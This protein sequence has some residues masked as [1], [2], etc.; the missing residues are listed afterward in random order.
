MSRTLGITATIGGIAILVAVFAPGRSP[1]SPVSAQPQ[2]VP[3]AK[4]ATPEEGIRAITAEY[5][6][7]FNAADAKSAA[8]L[9]TANGE[10]IGADGARVVGRDAIE[11]DL[12]A[13]FKANPKVQATVNIES[14]RLIGRG[15]AM[16]EGLVT[17]RRPAEPTPSESRYSALHVNEEG[18]W[19][20]ASVREWELDHATDIDL[21][22]LEWM[23]GEWKAKGDAEVH[24][25]YAWDESKTFINGKY[26]VEKDG[27][28]IST[29]KQVFARNPQGGLRSWMFDSSGTTGEAIWTRD[30]TRWV[31]DGTATLTDG[32]EVNSTSVIIPIGKDSFTWQATERSIDGVTLPS[33][34]PLK[35]TR[36]VK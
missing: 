35:V 23:V 27:K 5:V 29:G 36:V 33:L 24:L 32:L 4:A 14:I 10:Y 28:V 17:V 9:W 22:H 6:K 20:A 15:T 13:F 21:K 26:T 7:A 2:P 16:V 12:A 19:H 25:S 31:S 30:G 18:V 1:I 34:P 3:P 8:L 11:K